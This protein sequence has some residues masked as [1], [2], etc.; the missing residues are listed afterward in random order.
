MIVEVLAFWEVLLV[1][2]VVVSD[3]WEGS[4]VIGDVL[5]VGGGVEEVLA[6]WGGVEGMLIVVVVV[7]SDSPGGSEV[8]GSVVTGVVVG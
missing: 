7:V 5:A 6:F 2:V 3:P 8:N 4:E 1:V